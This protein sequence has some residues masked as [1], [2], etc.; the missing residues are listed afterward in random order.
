MDLGLLESLNKPQMSY[1]VK[2]FANDCGGFAPRARPSRAS[3]WKQSIRSAFQ[4][5]LNYN[6]LLQNIG[7]Q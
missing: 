7:S 2:E 5:N 4:T 3:P 1:G 6:K